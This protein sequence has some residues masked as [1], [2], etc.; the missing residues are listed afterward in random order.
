MKDRFSLSY[1]EKLRENIIRKNSELLRGRIPSY[2]DQI[3]KAL[4]RGDANSVQHRI[5][6]FLASYFDVIYA[7]NRQLHPGEKKLLNKTLRVCP[8]LPEHFEEDLQT[9]F[10]TPLIPGDGIIGLVNRMTDRLNRLT[11]YTGSA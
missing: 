8:D 1:P 9:L 5:T 3:R 6:A 7:F 10:S 11:G 2:E 4:K